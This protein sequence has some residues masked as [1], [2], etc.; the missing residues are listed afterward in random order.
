MKKIFAPDLMFNDYVKNTWN[1]NV[2][3]T[4][5]G[6][7]PISKDI[8]ESGNGYAIQIEPERIK[9]EADYWAMGFP[10]NKSWTDEH[11]DIKDPQLYFESVC[12]SPM[13]IGVKYQN[14]SVDDNTKVFIDNCED[15]KQ[16]NIPVPKK[17]GKK[18]N[19]IVFS[20]PILDQIILIKN[21]YIK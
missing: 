11:I 14:K 3:K 9:T 21:I 12:S 8:R 1:V 19:L 4:D 7:I 13:N 20:G 5:G 2:K 17:M 16:Y 10:L 6:F 18:I 15:W